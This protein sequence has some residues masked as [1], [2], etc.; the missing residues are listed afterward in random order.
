MDFDETVNTINTVLFGID[1][2]LKNSSVRSRF[3][4]V[5]V[6]RFGFSLFFCTQYSSMIYR[7][8]DGRHDDMA[9]ITTNLL[10]SDGRTDGELT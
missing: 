3:A 9:T 2:V 8:A 10:C 4:V 7:R 6:K 5:I 1:V